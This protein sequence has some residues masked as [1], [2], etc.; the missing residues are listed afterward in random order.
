MLDGQRFNFEKMTAYQIEQLEKLICEKNK[1][2]LIAPEGKLRVSKRGSRVQFYQVVNANDPNGS[3][4]RKKEKE[5]LIRALAQKEYDAK[6]R[7]AAET[8]LNICKKMLERAVVGMEH[9]YENLPLEKRALV[10]PIRSDDETFV[11]EWLARP[12]T[13]NRFQKDDPEQYTCNG[14][15]V[16]SKSEVMVAEVLTELGV[17]YKCEPELYLNGLGRIYPDFLVL[18]VKTRKEFYY[19]HLG[20]LG[21][22]HYFERQLKKIYS[23]AEN[24]Y[25]PGKNLIL[26]FESQENPITLPKLKRMLRAYLI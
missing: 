23:Y 24:G 22:A 3:Y 4:L 13:R 9:I 12:Y 16:R 26:T 17:P 20:M 14:E 18:N 7:S 2:L 10:E 8:E 19:E 21:D 25:F 11:K 15:R 5:G 1:A 6:V